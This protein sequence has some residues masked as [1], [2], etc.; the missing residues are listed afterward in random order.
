MDSNLCPLAYRRKFL[1]QLFLGKPSCAMQK[2]AGPC[3]IELYMPR[4]SKIPI[5][6]VT[7]ATHLANWVHEKYMHTQKARGFLQPPESK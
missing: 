3:S 6:V 7:L 5:L 2:T 1:L 4:D